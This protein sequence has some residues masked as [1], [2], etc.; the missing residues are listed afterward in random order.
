MAQRG[1]QSRAQFCGCDDKP[2]RGPLDT[3]DGIRQPPAAVTHWEPD[4][5][6]GQRRAEETDNSTKCHMFMA[7]KC[8][9]RRLDTQNH[10]S[11]SFCQDIRFGNKH[12][13]IQPAIS[14]MNQALWTS[15][16]VIPR[17]IRITDFQYRIRNY[18]LSM[19]YFGHYPQSKDLDY[20]T[21]STPN[22]N[23]ISSTS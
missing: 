23:P 9:I 13:H 5:K 4:Q 15:A 8:Q 21:I 11:L 7:L 12:G 19:P 17:Q 14:L 10:A 22:M 18:V 2:L 20:N 1:S 6:E 3:W 16:R